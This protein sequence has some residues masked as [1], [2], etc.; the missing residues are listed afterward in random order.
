MFGRTV[1]PIHAEQVMDLTGPAE[2][3]DPPGGFPPRLWGVVSLARH[4]LLM[5]DHDGTL[6]P[7][8]MVRTRAIPS[9][10]TLAL[11]HRV[12]GSGHT[13]LVVVSGRPVHELAHLFGQPPWT[14]VGEHGWEWAE[15]GGPVVR[16]PL[17]RGV[18]TRLEQ[19]ERLVRETGLGERIER[20]RS[21]IAVHTRGLDVPQ[22]HA[23]AATAARV[24]T[25]VMDDALMR[26][27]SFEGGVELRVRGRDKGTAARDL[28]ARE[29]PGT[30]GV[31]VGDDDTDEDAFTALAPTGI[32][33]RVGA[34]GVPTGASAWLH[35]PEQVA[36]FLAAWLEK[37]D[38]DGASRA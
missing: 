38:G 28:L 36:R 10:E 27:A 33:V 17:P 23:V 24:W 11:L 16:H 26:L 32:G 31:H 21:S 4:R 25:P 18:A 20:K 14:L 6:V 37:L 3:P 1:H 13:T 2:L 19:A 22:A 8:E 34:P 29:V 9:G 15:P 12:A 35:G 5:L 7:F 30:L